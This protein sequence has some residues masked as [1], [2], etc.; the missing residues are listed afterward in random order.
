MVIR[1]GKRHGQR[2]I[3]RVYT[4]RSFRGR[5]AHV[6]RDEQP[7]VSYHIVR[8]VWET[9]PPRDRGEKKEREEGSEKGR[10]RRGRKRK[11]RERKKRGRGNDSERGG[12]AFNQ[13]LASKCTVHV[14]VYCGGRK[15]E[16][17]GGK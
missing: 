16:R 14:Y 2:S 4:R 1:G 9:A 7:A 8:A 10:P 12:V 15:G 6:L 3:I 13:S 11:G 17:R 5:H